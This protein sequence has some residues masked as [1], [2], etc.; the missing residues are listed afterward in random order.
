VKAVQRSAVSMAGEGVKS[1]VGD[2]YGVFEGSE[3]ALGARVSLD[4]FR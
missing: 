4:A 3:P 1:G 2:S